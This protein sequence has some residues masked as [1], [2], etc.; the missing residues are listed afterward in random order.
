[1]PH[2]RPPSARSVAKIKRVLAILDGHV[3]QR[4]GLDELAAMAGFSRSYFSRIFHAVAGTSLR[5]YLRAVKLER[6]IELVR[7]STRSLTDIAVESGFYD[8][9]HLDK[10]FRQRFG[11]SPYNFR[12]RHTERPKK[13]QASKAL[14]PASTFRQPPSA[15]RR[16]P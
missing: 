1:M 5:D 7:S 15:S 16:V 11:M 8:L 3:G 13:A 4:H 9:A 6:A 12:A 2:S 14:R 10:A